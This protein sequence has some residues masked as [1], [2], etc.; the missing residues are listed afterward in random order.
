[1]TD[2]FKKGICSALNSALQERALSRNK[3]AAQAGVSPATLSQALNANW[4]HISDAMW[5]KMAT[6]AGVEMAETKWGI[7]ETPNFTMLTEMAAFVKRE[8]LCRAV[9]GFAGAG[10]TTALKYFSRNNPNVYYVGADSYFSQSYF[11]LTIRKALG[12]PLENEPLAGTLERIIGYLNAVKRPLLII[13]EADKLKDSCL[14]FIKSIYDG[15]EGHCG[16]LLAGVDHLRNRLSKGAEKHKMGYDELYSRLGRKLEPCARPDKAT[17][18]TIC[19]QMGITD[20]GTINAIADKAQDY[21]QVKSRVMDA[22]YLMRHEQ[23]L[24]AA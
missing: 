21:R 20:K 8:S 4:A 12:L 22:L 6:W 14:Q 11:V 18:T 17:I 7:F 1:M 19:A 2:E 13:D 24:A 9:A 3:A 5:K 15:T 23:K 10:K 16:I